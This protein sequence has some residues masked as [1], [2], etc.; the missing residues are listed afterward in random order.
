MKILLVEDDR[1]IGWGLR[2]G[3]LDEGFAV[4]WLDDGDAAIVVCSEHCYDAAI[5][6]LGW[7]DRRARAGNVRRWRSCRVAYPAPCNWR[8][9]Y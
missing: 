2:R 1:M 4:D 9:N 8:V 3:L 7:L 6:D 5:L